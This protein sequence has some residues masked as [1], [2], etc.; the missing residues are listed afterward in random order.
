MRFQ[1]VFSIL[2]KILLIIG[3]CM[4]FPLLWSLYYHEKDVLGL[5]YAMMS[6]ILAGGLLC[7]FLKSKETIRQREGFA[8]VTL[9]WIMASLFGALP[10]LFTGTL[11]SFTDA[12]FETMSGFTTTGASVLG[13][14]EV[15]SHGIVFW[16]CLTHWLGGMGF[17]LLFV[18]LL[19][20]I[21]GGG[22]QMF[23]AEAPGGRLAEKIKPRIQDSA[24][25]LWA[26]Y[27]ILSLTLM[28]LLLL[29]GMNF[30]DSLCHAF[31]TMATGG[32]STKSQNIGYYDS[33]YIQWMIT[34]FMFAAGA[35]L[36]L[37]Y[38]SIYKRTFVF[39]KNEEFRLYLLITLTGVLLVFLDL[40]R[41]QPGGVEET[42]RMAA[43]QV[44]S[45]LTTTGYASVDFNQWPV[46]S[47]IM[48]LLIMFV[49]GCSGST[50]GAIKVGR[51][52]IL[53]KHTWVEI[54]R[55]IHPRSIKY[56]KIGHKIVPEN[57]VLNT[58]QFFFL[59]ITIF[60]IGTAVM[61]ALGLDMVESLTSVISSL[62]N[63][64]FG[65][66]DVG[67]SGNFAH[68]PGAGKWMLCFLM[69]LGRLEIF[70]VLVLFL[71]EVWKKA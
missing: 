62:S 8:I 34:F 17:M 45:M 55:L 25:I 14:I 31:G 43:F 60:F 44:V 58:L 66:G 41:N 68:I 59:Y 12:F 57:I 49:G 9:G 50:G 38:Q 67:P 26:T 69:L 10:Y 22:L 30:F 51:L 70:T 35:N 39:W 40:M 71:P 18:A 19:S 11:T 48:L 23:K 54:F 63:V 16:R 33:S 46:F 61:G 24:K 2:G 53:I 32:F 56:L 21:G 15:L 52:L 36:A 6:T 20:Q 47:K 65:L 29:G 42:L 5:F 1:L 27:V 13:N 4:V 3:G 28:I 7:F 37:F 64:G